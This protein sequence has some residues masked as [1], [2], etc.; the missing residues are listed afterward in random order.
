M[1][2]TAC[3]RNYFNRLSADDVEDAE[4]AEERARVLADAAALKKLAVDYAHPELPIGTSDATAC[5]RNYFNRMSADDVEDAEEAEER[6]RVLADAVALKKLAV[7]YAH[8]ELPIVTS[9]ATACARN[10]F[11]RMSADDVEDA[12]EAEERARVLADAA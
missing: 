7:D 5:A 6:A 4:E 8:P 11:N 2:A 10:Y 1:G 3:A 12:E 9:D